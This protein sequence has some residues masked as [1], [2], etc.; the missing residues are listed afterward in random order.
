MKKLFVLLLALVS[1]TIVSADND[2]PIGFEEL[3]AAAR[4][5]IKTHFPESRVAFATVERGLWPSYDVIFDD[6]MQIEFSSTGEW[7]E[8]DCKYS[9]IPES[10]IPVPILSFLK[11]RHPEARVRD[12]ERNRVGYE[13]NLDN[14]L[15][16]NFWANGQLRG[17]DD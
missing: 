2:R 7:T 4:Q 6:G 10:V 9:H 8:I 5:F 13:L 17:Y 3:P 15:E 12:I 1:A 14:R 11:Q 16:L